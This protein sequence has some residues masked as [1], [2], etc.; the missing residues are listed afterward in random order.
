MADTDPNVANPMSQQQWA[1]SAWDTEG[2][3]GPCGP[4]EE[5]GIEL[6]PPQIP[7]LTNAELVQLRVRV[8]ALENLVIAL[9]A[10]TT[11]RQLAQARSMAA[12]ISPRPGFTQH[13]M[14]L[15]AAT[16]M[17]NLIDRASPFRSADVYSR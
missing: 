9:L 8:I 15:H 14:T 7:D 10:R 13:P 17:I 3:A 1:L 16:H 4:Q 6:S 12:H 2:G 5:P 11:D